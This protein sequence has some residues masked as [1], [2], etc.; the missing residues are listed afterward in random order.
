VSPGF[1]LIDVVTPPGDSPDA[2]PDCVEGEDDAEDDDAE[3]DA[4]VV[5]FGDEQAAA[6]PTATAANTPDTA[7][8]HQR[9]ADMCA[10]LLGVMGVMGTR[11]CC[12]T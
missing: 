9:I 7:T 8:S 11:E 5:P 12:R 6:A 1:A 2:E 10:R 4:G 3:D